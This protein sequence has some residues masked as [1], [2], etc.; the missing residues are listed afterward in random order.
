M[1]GVVA[2]FCGVFRFGR[3]SQARPRCAQAEARAKSKAKATHLLQCGDVGLVELLK[4]DC[5]AVGGNTGGGGRGSGVRVQKR[6]RGRGL[7]CKT[8]QLE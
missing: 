6:R 8:R 3:S 2:G 4:V 1:R 5:G 7:E